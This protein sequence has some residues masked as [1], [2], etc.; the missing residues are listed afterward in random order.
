MS[1]KARNEPADNVPE[2]SFTGQ[3]FQC[4]E[5]SASVQPL[6]TQKTAG[7]GIPAPRNK[8]FRMGSLP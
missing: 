4:P 6:D 8:T 1:A 5:F 2:R 7:M 3:L